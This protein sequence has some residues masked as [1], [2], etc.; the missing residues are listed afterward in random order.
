MNF[1]CDEKDINKSC[2]QLFSA[3]DKSVITVDFS[4]I[5]LDTTDLHNPISSILCI[6]H[7][8]KTL[9]FDAQLSIQIKYLSICS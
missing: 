1:K 6:N 8:R 2:D 5:S 4:T 9:T 7:N 3:I